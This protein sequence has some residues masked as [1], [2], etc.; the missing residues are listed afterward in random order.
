MKRQI[1]NSVCDALGVQVKWLPK[2][3]NKFQIEL[4][5]IIEM[6]ES[7]RETGKYKRFS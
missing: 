7:N 3:V 6:K 1:S 5:L 4:R 2:R